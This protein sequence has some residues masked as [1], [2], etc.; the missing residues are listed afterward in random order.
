MSTQTE[1]TTTATTTHRCYA[2]RHM[3][4][5]AYAVYNVC[6]SW[7][8]QKDGDGIL[9][10]NG[11]KLA[12]QFEGMSKNTFYRYCSLLEER[13][14][15]ILLKASKRLWDGTWSARHYQVLS[16]DE[17]AAGH[18]GKCEE[19][20]ASNLEH[21]ETPVPNNAEPVPNP[22]LDAIPP[23]PNID[24]PVPNNAST[25]PGFGTALITKLIPKHIKE[26]IEE[27]P[28]PDLGLEV[29][30][31]VDRFSKSSKRRQRKEPEGQHVTGAPVPN[32]GLDVSNLYSPSL[33]MDIPSQALRL[34]TPLVSTLGISDQGIKQGWN[35]AMESLLQQG[36]SQEAIHSAA[37]FAAD[38]LR[39]SMLHPAHGA[40]GFEK[41]FGAIK[42]T[43]ERAQTE[44]TQ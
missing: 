29:S 38:N 8:R 39:A 3:P 5:M 19:W 23:V 44:V 25:C 43:A 31:F 11:R 12:A 24:Q 26:P 13:G 4:G 41:N 34:S 14:W 16:H 30:A 7:S 20:L 18:L 6:L 42:A 1:T 33:P 17:W 28:V 22:G 40:E 15:F 37:Q 21:C 27:Q 32:P 35:R 36:Y 9:Y 2:H 10:C